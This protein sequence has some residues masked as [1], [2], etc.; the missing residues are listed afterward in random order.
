MAE[1][2]ERHEGSSGDGAH[3][4][5]PRPVVARFMEA[6]NDLDPLV[7]HVLLWRYGL[8][9]LTDEAIAAQV[10][11]PVERVVAVSE[12]ALRQVWACVARPEEA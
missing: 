1:R 10:G 4:R 11:W 8:R 2:K 7:S 3:Q 9:S 5:Q 12:A 6:I